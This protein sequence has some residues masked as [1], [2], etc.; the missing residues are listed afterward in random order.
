MRTSPLKLV[1]RI[2]ARVRV[3]RTVEGALAG[4][5][6]Q[7]LIRAQPGSETNPPRRAARLINPDGNLMGIG[8][9]LKRQS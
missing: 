1:S 7:R 5:V 9:P 2:I 3:Q 6:A 8:S 4:S